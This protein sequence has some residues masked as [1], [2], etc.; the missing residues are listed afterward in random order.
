M[1]KRLPGTAML[2]QLLVTKPNLCCFRR[3][4]HLPP[5]FGTS[6]RNMAACTRP[7]SPGKHSAT[8]I[9]LHGLGDTGK[10]WL[11]N[12]SEIC[13]GHIKIIC[14]NAPIAPVSLNFGMP[15][16]SWF[17]IK[18]L[19]FDADEDE[20]GIVASA[21]RVKGIMT[22]EV[23]AGIPMSRIVVGGFSQGGA[24]AL[25]TFLSHTEKLGGC[26]GLST[27][28]P[29]STKFQDNATPANKD[30]KVF[31]AHGNSDPVVKFQF[32]EMTNNLMKTH[33]S[34]ISWNKYS[35]LGHSSST[36]EMKDLKKFL[37]GVIGKTS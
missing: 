28:L 26:V 4:I 6:P 10:G 32:G 12:L 34:E 29:L 27:F 3:N 11:E 35:G 15:M 8:L 31:L 37:E 23:A 5:W 18:S 25:H 21:D 36:S 9:F 16:P 1:G 20:A 22:E 7:T 19:S 33:Y 13:P 30:T 24:V 17:D 2:L 14:P